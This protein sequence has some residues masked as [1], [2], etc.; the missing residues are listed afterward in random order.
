MKLKKLITALVLVAIVA[1]LIPTAA[2]AGLVPSDWATAEMNDANVNGLLTP[3]AAKDFARKLTREDF[4]E[5][6]VVLT[7]KLL[8]RELSLPT[9]N[10]F[11][12]TN[13]KS[14]L[15]AYQYGIINGTTTTTFSPNS[16]VTRQQIAAMMIRAYKQME[17]EL[18]RTLLVAPLPDLSFNDKANI[19]DYAIEPV[20]YAVA[21]EMFK[22]DDLNNFNPLNDIR[23]EECVAVIIRSYNKVLPLFN[24]GLSES[25]LI[26]KATDNLGI[27]FAY[28]DTASGI[29]QDITLP[30]TTMGGATVIWTSSNAGIISTAGK[31]T[32]YNNATVTLTATVRIGNSTR[33]K[34]FTLTTTTLTGDTRLLSNAYSELE[35]SFRN[36]GDSLTRV[37]DGIFLPTSIL[38]LP[39]TWTSSNSSVVTNTGTVFVPYDNRQLTATLT[40]S[41]GVGS[42]TRTKQF[43][44]TVR[45]SNFVD[46]EI[47]LHNIKIGMTLSE[48]TSA[49]GSSPKRTITLSSGEVWSIYYSV[50]AS[51]TS[52]PNAILNF[53]A[54]AT[55]STGANGRIIGVYSMVSGWQSYLRDGTKTN[56]TILTPAQVNQNSDV[57]ITAYSLGSTV[58]A[59]LL[60]ERN[61]AI[62]K[63]RTLSVASLEAFMLDLFN[64][65]RGVNSRP[66]IS[67][68]AQLASSARSHSADLTRYDIFNEAGTT[69]YRTYTARA[70]YA[71]YNGTVSGMLSANNIDPFN[72]LADLIATTSN[73]NIILSTGTNLTVGI[74]AST[75][76]G[77]TYS[78]ILTTVFGTETTVPITNVTASSNLNV[79]VGRSVNVTL[80]IAPT[81]YVEDFTVTSSNTN[82]MT[83]TTTSNPAIVTIYGVRSGSANL[84]VRTASN[85]TFTIPITIGDAYAS[86]ITIGNANKKYIAAVGTNTLQLNAVVTAQSGST[87]TTPN[88]VV[89][90]SGTSGITVSVNGVVTIPSNFTGSSFTVTAWLPSSASQTTQ[91]N[92]TAKDSVTIYIARLTVAATDSFDLGVPPDHKLA[93]TPSSNIAAGTIGTPT[94]VWTVPT[95]NSFSVAADGTV[96][97][98]TT[99]GTQTA[100]ATLSYSGCNGVITANTRVTVTGNSD[101]PTSATASPTSLSLEIG[102][103]KDIIVSPVP[104]NVTN[105]IVSVSSTSPNFTVSVVGTTVRVTGV[106][107]T[108]GAEN[109]EIRIQTGANAGNVFLINVPVTVTKKAVTLEISSQ[110][111]FTV[112]NSVNLVAT[113]NDAGNGLPIM[114]IISGGTPGAATITS[115]GSFEALAP[116]TVVV[117]ASIVATETTLA[118]EAHLT[119][120]ILPDTP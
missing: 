38:G 41:F 98:K 68:N 11:T 77:G 1:T 97:L 26:A 63:S 94:V 25:S 47:Y 7:E 86:N 93:A 32:P 92:T 79:G 105:K 106:A 100:L 23:S 22:G 80:T 27:G 9:G 54:V 109:L 12:D 64:A 43:T 102:E 82:F 73:R 112:G 74:G 72:Y 56:S 84:V 8:G 34:N 108:A 24:S 4:C 18:S 57:M 107:S 101:W 103:T 50:S 53:V 110:N 52:N 113:T 116:G 31:V 13:S 65:Y 39:V 58:Y 111:Q 71:G 29:S 51:N 2:F 99:T 36:P 76:T 119:I 78:D 28:G 75:G 118:A 33:T 46:A 115:N 30:T 87:L 45:N 67:S 15:K 6:V 85:R 104:T 59:G 48:A 96:T 44:I 95:N 49:L 5:L 89:A 10:P 60:A 88:W 37:T 81:N 61:S 3:N 83:V 14:A 117:T 120:T 16:N 91:N 17:V 62:T 114:W 20:R 40:A 42:N 35:L 90:G 19:Q 21:N 66:Q 69:T 70:V 55:S